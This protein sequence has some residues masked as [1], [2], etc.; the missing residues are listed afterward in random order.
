MGTFDKG[1]LLDGKAVVITNPVPFAKGGVGEVFKG[2]YDGDVVA[3]KRIKN[4]EPSYLIKSM[5]DEVETLKSLNHARIIRF[6][7]II[8][9]EGSISIV[10][11][12]MKTSLFAYYGENP[13]HPIEDRVLW[14]LDIAYGIKYLH[15]HKPSII[16]RDLKTS[17]VLLSLD[18]EGKLR[19]KISDFGSAMQEISTLATQVGEKPDY[20]G[21]TLYYRAPELGL[22][23]EFNTATDVYAYGVVF[24]E[25]A[26]WQGPFGIPRDQLNADFLRGKLDQGKPIFFDLSECTFPPSLKDLI[27]RCAGTKDT[28]PSIRT[29]IK[30]ISKLRTVD[31]M[32]QPIHFN[33]EEDANTSDEFAGTFLTKALTGR[34]RLGE[35]YW[36]GRGVERDFKEAAKWYLKSAQN[37]PGNSMGQY[38]I[39]WCLFYGQGVEKEDRQEALK[40]LNLSAAQGNTKS[41][42]LLGYCYYM[43]EGVEKPDYQLAMKWYKLAAEQASGS[44]IILV[45]ELRNQIIKKQSNGSKG[46]QNRGMPNLRTGVEKQFDHAF[47]WF[48]KSA[49]QGNAEAQHRLGDC[50]WYGNGVEK[51]FKNA[52]K[53]YLESAE[54]GN[55]NGQYGIGWCLHKGEG[56]RRPYLHEAVKWYTLS[57]QSGRGNSA[58]QNL[59]GTLFESGFHEDGQP[60]KK[61]LVKAREW[62]TKAANQGHEA[63]KKRLK[64]MPVE[65]Q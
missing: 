36:Y 40:W 38:S 41:Q 30:L 5:N 17:N 35:I 55:L 63:A 19:P 16:H 7:G 3:V 31:D 56:F 44:C 57:A 53:W 2:E 64:E 20:R 34:P 12:M 48:T 10:L 24:S 1:I 45:K 65:S 28:R 60:L 29:V 15:E 51:D 43:G 50:Y 54:Q 18:N 14:A 9:E 21:T 39:G 49:E 61:D 46:L 23:A 42:I 37:E 59:L 6:Y 62:Y 4:P 8:L 52:A 26:S 33:F 22:R 13:I 32:F 47:D 27:I 25:I 11:E 58:A